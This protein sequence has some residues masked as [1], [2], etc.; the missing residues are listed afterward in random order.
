M[1]ANDKGVPEDEILLA[2]LIQNA[3]SRG[4]KSTRYLLYDGNPDYSQPYQCAPGNL[5]TA[6]CVIGAA[7]LSHDTHE[8]L[9]WGHRVTDAAIKGNNFEDGQDGLEADPSLF[10]VGAAFEQALRPEKV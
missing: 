4:F 3:S 9:P 1:K 6:C 7:Q 8:V 10:T 5:T 2:K